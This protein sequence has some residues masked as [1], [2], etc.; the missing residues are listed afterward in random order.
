MLLNFHTIYFK[1]KNLKEF[2][3]PNYVEILH[4]KIPNCLPCLALFGKHFLISTL[5]KIQQDPHMHKQIGLTIRW[6]QV[7]GLDF[8][9]RQ[10]K[11][12]VC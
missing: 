9:I 7:S 8:R 4:E 10:F 3:W 1:N 5:C 12:I 11:T 2:E 6:T